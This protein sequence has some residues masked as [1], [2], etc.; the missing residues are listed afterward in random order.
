MKKQLRCMYPTDAVATLEE[1][2]GPKQWIRKVDASSVLLPVTIEMLEDERGF[3]VDALLDSG[4]HRYYVDHCFIERNHL[5]LERLPR[6]VPVY[7]ADGSVSKAGPITHVVNLGLRIHDH[8]ETFR[9]AITDTGTSDLIIGFSWLRL[10]NPTVDWRSGDVV[11]NQCPQL[12]C[13]LVEDDDDLEEGDRV[14]MCQIQTEEQQEERIRA[15]QTHAQKFAAAAAK[16]GIH[17]E[18]IEDHVPARYLNDFHQVFEA[19]EFEYLPDCRRWDHAIGDAGRALSAHPT[20]P[21]DS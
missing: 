15:F 5:P 21:P 20:S 8:Q 10:H 14:F 1:L 6:A 3:T 11:F 2:R 9:C 12:C 19:G 18:N 7:M 13:S 4:A 16:E 17:A